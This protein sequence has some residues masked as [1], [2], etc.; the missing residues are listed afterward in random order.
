MSYCR[1]SSDCHQCDV[2]V[3]ADV[4]GGWTTHVAGRKRRPL[5]PC[6]KPSSGSEDT[7]AERYVSYWMECTKWVEDESNW[8]WEDI[9][10]SDAGESFNDP[11]ASECAARLIRYKAEGLYVPQYAIDA[12]LDEA[13]EEAQG[14]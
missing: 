6:P 13:S 7:F 10:H 11:T 2:Y 4:D 12:L 3:Y 9:D 1:W 14:S 8:R 5:K